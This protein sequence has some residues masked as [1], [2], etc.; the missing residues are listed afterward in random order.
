[1]C[2]SN[3]WRWLRLMRIWKNRW[4]NE[5]RSLVLRGSSNNQIIPIRT[6]YSVQY[7][8][9]TQHMHTAMNC[10]FTWTTNT[11][12][13]CLFYFNCYLAKCT[14]CVH[15]VRAIYANGNHRS[16]AE[17]NEEKKGNSVVEKNKKTEITHHLLCDMNFSTYWTW[18]FRYEFWSVW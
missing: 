5:W 16:W 13:R 10:R 15:V 8:Y 11:I 14:M 17:W 3:N 6:V 1:M 9:T 4:K 2:H 7:T 12:Y 18:P